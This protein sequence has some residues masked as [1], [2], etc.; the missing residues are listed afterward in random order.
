M[1]TL[2]R[3][4][5]SSILGPLNNGF[6]IFVLDKNSPMFSHSNNN[7]LP[8][9]IPLVLQQVIS[10]ITTTEISYKD[11]KRLCCTRYQLMQVVLKRIPKE[12]LS[13]NHMTLNHLWIL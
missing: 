9:E 13:K 11:R 10:R 3:I 6:D 8:K 12:I 7:R 5:E 1:E 4:H 2:K